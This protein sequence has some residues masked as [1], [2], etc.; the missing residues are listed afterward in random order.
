MDHL[1]MRRQTRV[2]VIGGMNMDILGLADVP[3]REFDSLTGRV[4][5][6]PGGVGRNIAQSLAETGLQ[7]ELMTVLGNDDNSRMLRASCA[8]FGINLDFSLQ[9][10]APSP[11][12]LAMHDQGGEMRTAIN[13]MRA[14]TRLSPSFI[15]EK[16]K[17]LSDCQACVLDAN[18]SEDCLVSAAECLDIPLVADPVSEVKCVRLKAILHRLAAIKPNRLEAETL[19]G[20]SSPQNAAKA[21]MNMGTEQVFISLGSDGLFYAGPN[22]SGFLDAPELT[23]VSVTGA[24]DAMAAG[25]TLGIARGLATR[26]TAELGLR[27]ST[28][29]LL[30]KNSSFRIDN[31]EDV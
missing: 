23:V 4:E 18:L 10:D 26:E 11:V 6:R 3:Y 2:L 22:G 29:Y 19:T 14:L 17:E 25:I 12:Y 5:M 13:D 30:R 1:E 27:F 15:R 21:L 28:D 16:L 20:E 24:G 31:E 9:T 7:V 8:H